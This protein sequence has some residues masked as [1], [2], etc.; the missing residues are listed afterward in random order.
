ME[1]RRAGRG[2]TQAYRASAFVV[3]LVG[4]WSGRGVGL[5]LGGRGEGERADQD[6]VVYC[7]GS[8]SEGTLFMDAKVL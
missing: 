2:Y 5:R 6:T 3:A 4:G 8:E 7:G 1:E